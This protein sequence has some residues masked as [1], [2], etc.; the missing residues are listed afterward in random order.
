M[1][2]RLALLSIAVICLGVVSLCQGK[3]LSNGYIFNDDCNQYTFSYY[4][5]NDPQLFQDDIYTTY[6]LRYNAKGVIFIYA[7]L[8]KIVDPLALSKILPFILCFVAALYAFLIGKECYDTDVGF[9]A[10]VLFI[11]HSWTFSCFSGGHAKAFVFPLLLS[12]IFYLIKK[13]YWE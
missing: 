8:G 5:L 3:A 9:T 4:Q 10:A 6:A 13:K 2:K 12:L 7:F 11:V 1:G